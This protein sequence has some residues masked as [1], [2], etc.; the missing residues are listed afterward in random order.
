MLFIKNGTL[1]NLFFKWLQLLRKNEMIELKQMV[2]RWIQSNCI[3]N[4]IKEIW[5]FPIS[6]K[7]VGSLR[8]WQK[9]NQ[10]NSKEVRKWMNSRT[11]TITKTMNE[12]MEDWKFP[13]FYIQGSWIGEFE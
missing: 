11:K 12:P 8:I 10:T 9:L 3:I 2:D 1:E 7:K 5:K 4:E 13:N 6:P